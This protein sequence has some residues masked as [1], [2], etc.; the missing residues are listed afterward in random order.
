MSFQNDALSREQASQLVDSQLPPP[1]TELTSERTVALAWAVKEL[2]YSSWSSEPQRAVRA[3]SA[4][5][6]LR[7]AARPGFAQGA[8]TEV[9]ALVD[10]TDGI[11]Q[12]IQGEMSAATASLDAAA[13][14]FVELG[15]ACHAAQ[16]QVP[17]IMAL[18]MLG[19]HEEAAQCAETALSA[20]LE[21]GDHGTASK[22]LLNL[23][24]LHLRADRYR[25][26]ADRFREATVLFSRT[27][28]SEHAVMADIGLADASAALGDL[29]EAARI[30]EGARTRAV[31]HGFPVLL[32]LVEE[33]VALIDL[34]RGRYREALAGLESSR[35]H[36]AALEMPQHLAIA[37]K[38]LADAYLELRLLPEALAGHA[39]ALDRFQALGM[40]LDRAWT[41]VQRGRA[42][43]LAHQRAAA[44]A[45]L[46]EAAALFAT[47]SN[48]AGSAAVALA[49]AEL[50]LA[51]VEPQRALNLARDAAR[52][53]KEVGLLERQLRAEVVQAQS[54]L[55]VGD[56]AAARALFDA[57][58]VA[59]RENHLHPVQLRCLTGRALAAEALGD[60][61]TARADLESAASMF[62]DQRRTLP[63]DELRSAFQSDHLL[64][65]EVLLRMELDAHTEGR[66][67]AADVL[68]RLDRFRARTLADRLG[69]TDQVRGDGE[70]TGET[71]LTG[72]Q[73]LRARLAWLYRRLHQLRDAG[74]EM[75]TVTAELRS[76]EQELLERMR[77][78]RL[79]EAP[80]A[81][82]N[83]LADL[84]P[85]SLQSLLGPGDALVEYGVVDDELFACVVTRKGVHV[86]RS[87]AAWAQVIDAVRAVR[88][89]METLRHGSAPVQHLLPALERR[90]HA[91]L[92]QLHALIW[93]PLEALLSERHRVLI[94]PH[95][96]LGSVP[97][98]ALHDGECSL[99]DR[100]QIAFAPSAR[101]ALRALA[102]EPRAAVTVLALGE[103][104]RLPHAAREAHAVS[105]L[106][107]QGRAFVGAEATIENLRAHA[108]TADVIHL[109]C[110]AQFRTDNPAFSALHLHDGVLTAEGIGDLHVPGAN[111][112][113][114]GCETALSDMGGGDEM[115]G[116]TRAFLVAGASRVL[117]ALWPVDDATTAEMMSVYYAGLRRGLLPGA[118]LRLAQQAV[119][120]TH[121][122]PF[123]WASFALMGRW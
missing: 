102:R 104:T 34:A 69:T 28:D 10:W 58:W 84:E 117:A 96:Q 61:Q 98:A 4:L 42:L 48:G 123:Y 2:C 60:R 16:T 112:V 78:I 70:G 109:A 107:P 86:Q 115:F 29:D 77:R 62:E 18:A 122:H 13:A 75:A 67:E 24:S 43:A 36:Y 11:A 39:A 85:H 26:A 5:R 50:E 79:S 21:T 44:A 120:R 64:P 81:Q 19:R 71:R 53:F 99:V 56:I 20:L 47:L 110:H 83:A 65:F 27:S 30:Y 76:T 103:S 100:F 38:Q 32:A 114:S 63:G 57:T 35:Q 95:A 17:K 113:L 40:Q 37:E 106:L 6:S 46:A 49:Q 8:L 73:D 90:I 119:R 89:Q 111:I 68:V 72:A 74:G 22:V 92:R 94:V 97:F 116:L 31:A 45:P 93:Q 108:G 12:A 14:A 82:T 41:L 88:F 101:L 121:P 52:Q 54:L 1:W 7:D 3:A 87:L 91:H 80:S 55:K 15:Q 118:A 66:A 105:G 25:A 51:G 59:A 23:G 9:D 33:S